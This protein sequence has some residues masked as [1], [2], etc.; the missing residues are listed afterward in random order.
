M[1]RRRTGPEEAIWFYIEFVDRNSDGGRVQVV[2]DDF[3][4]VR[5][6]DAVATE[7]S[8]GVGVLGGERVAKR[9]R[10]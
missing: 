3:E 4:V 8:D 9:P 1:D 10:S 2:E 5:G 7:G 6:N